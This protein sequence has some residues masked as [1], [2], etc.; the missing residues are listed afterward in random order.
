[1][2][3]GVFV[4]LRHSAVD[5]P[6]KKVNGRKKIFMFE[7]MAAESPLLYID[8]NSLRRHGSFYIPRTVHYFLL[9]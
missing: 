5:K 2:T 3:G 6:R 7:A 1:M 9:D 8:K 4:S